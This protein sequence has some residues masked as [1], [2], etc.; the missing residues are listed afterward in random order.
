[1]F[2][3]VPATFLLALLWTALAISLSACGE[4]PPDGAV[5]SPG[6]VS[7]APAGD[8]SSSPRG[9]AGHVMAAELGASMYVGLEVCGA[10]DAR[11][12]ATRERFADLAAKQQGVLRED[13]DVAFDAR[14]PKA[15]SRVEAEA[16]TLPEG[17]KKQACKDMLEKP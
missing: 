3:N 10:D 17:H 15:R 9:L 5:T 11:L 6:P 13:F 4:S 8:A 1:M 14:L 16:A 7:Q 2:R 12:E